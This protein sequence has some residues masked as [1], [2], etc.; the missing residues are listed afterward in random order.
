M[1]TCITHVLPSLCLPFMSIFPILI[2]FISSFIFVSFYL[3]FLFLSSLSYTVL[4]AVC[5]LP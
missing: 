2:L 3:C 4:S 5:I 1:H